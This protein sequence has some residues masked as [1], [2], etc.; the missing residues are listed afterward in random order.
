VSEKSKVA[1]VRGKRP[2]DQAEIDRMVREAVNM[3]VG[4]SGKIK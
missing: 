3:V 4:L 2:P 1:I